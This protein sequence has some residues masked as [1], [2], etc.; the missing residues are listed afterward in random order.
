MTLSIII[1]IITI[2]LLIAT[3][4]YA[5]QL[6]QRIKSV[7]ANRDE[8]KNLLEGFSASLKVAEVSIEKLHVVGTAAIESMNDGMSDAKTLKDDLKYLI[9]RGERLANEL[10]DV[11]RAT[12]NIAQE[13][14]RQTDMEKIT[15]QRSSVNELETNMFDASMKKDKEPEDKTQEEDVLSE[16]KRRLMGRLAALK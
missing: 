16:V 4:V 10:E 11:I 8:L 14:V 6:N 3:I 15:P 1:D 5:L 13:P 12:R 7:H 2:S 9:D